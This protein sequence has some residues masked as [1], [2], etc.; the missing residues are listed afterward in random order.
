MT[1]N[2]LVVGSNPTGVTKGEM[3]LAGAFFIS[4]S[5]LNKQ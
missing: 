4:R 3:A 2:H 5:S 1:F